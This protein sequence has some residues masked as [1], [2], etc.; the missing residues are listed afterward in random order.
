[1]VRRCA[2]RW[3]QADN[4]ANAEAASPRPLL[5][6]THL[7]QHL[8]P[9]VLQPVAV[10]DR[11]WD[12]CHYFI[13]WQTTVKRPP[14]AVELAKCIDVRPRAKR[15]RMQRCGDFLVGQ[16]AEI[17]QYELGPILVKITKEQQPTTARRGDPPS[18][19]RHDHLIPETTQGTA[20]TPDTVRIGS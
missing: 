6:S 9:L 20:A 3:V 18:G 17:G 13:Q 8:L 11:R 14:T 10:G 12:V 15:Q 16:N 2:P 4:T 5:D 7:K 1:M 19:G